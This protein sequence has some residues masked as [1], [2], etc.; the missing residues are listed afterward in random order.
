M[1]SPAQV[2]VLSRPTPAASAVS[3]TQEQQ[4]AFSTLLELSDAQFLCPRSILDA[5]ARISRLAPL[6][7]FPA[8]APYE[9]TMLAL[10]ELCSDQHNRFSASDT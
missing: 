10:E 4:G 3:R 6:A 9:P 5:K 1:P 2:T 7:R 8:G